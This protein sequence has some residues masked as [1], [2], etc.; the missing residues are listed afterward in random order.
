MSVEYLQLV[1]GSELPFNIIEEPFRAIVL[2]ESN[3]SR[4]WQARVSVWLV[5][6][7]CLYMMAWGN[8]CSAWDDSVD[9]A[10]LEK[11]KYGEIPDDKQIITTWHENESL[12]EVFSFSKHNALHPAVLIKRSIIVHISTEFRKDRILELYKKS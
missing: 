3:V 9:Y 5:D 12:E 8:G 7:G 1:P 11:Y 6:S 4:E 10:N 2:I